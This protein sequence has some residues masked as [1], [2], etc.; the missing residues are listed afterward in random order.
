MSSCGTDEEGQP[1]PGTSGFRAMASRFVA[2]PA[3][4]VALLTVGVTFLHRFLIVRGEEFFRYTIQ[5]D[6]TRFMWPKLLFLT[7][8]LRLGIWP[9]WNPYDFAGAPVFSNL[10]TLYHHPLVLLYTATV[11]FS[12]ESLQ[13]YLL[14]LYLFGAINVF[15]LA[16]FLDVPSPLAVLFG[17]LYSMSG[18]ALGNATHF[19]QLHLFLTEPLTL[20]LLLR[21]A[22]QP[23]AASFSLAALGLCLLISAGYPSILGHLFVFDFLFTALA[24][25]GQ[26]RSHPRGLAALVGVFA[27]ACV[28]MAPMLVPGILSLPLITR[29]GGVSYEVFTSHSLPLHQLASVANPFL[30]LMDASL[31]DTSLMDKSGTKLEVTLRNCSIGI[32]VFMLVCYSAFRSSD[33][34]FL[35]LYLA[36][37]VLG[38]L[39]GELFTGRWFYAI[40]FVNNS[41]HVTFE[42]RALLILVAFLLAMLSAREYLAERRRAVIVLSLL[43]P[44]LLY[45]GFVL[46]IHEGLDLTASLRSLEAF[47]H[48]AFDDRTHRAVVLGL[49]ILFFL[50]YA[51]VSRAPRFAAVGILLVGFLEAF[52]VTPFNY[53]TVVGPAPP[54]AWRKNV[55]YERERNRGFPFPE[56]FR[57]SRVFPALSNYGSIH[58]VHT[59]WGMDGTVLR[60]ID[61]LVVSGDPR[62][63]GPYTWT[64]AGGRGESAL[65]GF[66]VTSF[67]PNRVEG[68]FRVVEHDVP[69]VFNFM[70]YP[71]WKAFSAGSERRTFLASGGFLGVGLQA[72]DSQLELRFSPTY[73]FRLVGLSAFV[74][75]LLVFGPAVGARVVARSNR[76]APT[77]RDDGNVSGRAPT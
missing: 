77:N 1:E 14:L 66:G 25:R 29:G 13:V 23:S 34:K 57:R 7:D 28:V 15:V 54:E 67:S 51:A 32:W 18:F 58:K 3:A 41:R 68:A 64:D 63:Y 30:G 12:L 38:C 55:E 43:L 22:R 11:G 24:L 21:F 31:M 17:L 36:I 40:P 47:T 76:G 26:A 2:S 60:S 48:R 61:R 9:L 56:P 42:F 16:R 19:P 37:S 70:H 49:P 8:S 50:G 59:D 5:W 46:S 44:L 69:V 39:G 62:L 72:G 73:Y 52:L 65:A 53:A 33:K 6:L 10:Q 4:S 74:I 75:L 71:G 35:L 20:Y 27:I 45:G